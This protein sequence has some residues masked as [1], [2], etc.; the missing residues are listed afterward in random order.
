ML[1][2]EKFEWKF[3][4]EL[5]AKDAGSAKTKCI[6]SDHNQ[7]NQNAYGKQLVTA[8]WNDYLRPVAVC[9]EEYS[10]IWIRKCEVVKLEFGG[11][12]NAQEFPEIRNQFV[13]FCEFNGTCRLKAPYHTNPYFARVG[14]TD[15]NPVLSVSVNQ[16]SFF[17]TVF[18][19]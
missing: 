14:F 10:G 3:Q 18:V 13:T 7:I 5:N 6:I 11:G 4:P 8:P 17:L 15:P 12:D 16:H 19:E 1:N 2:I 9:Q